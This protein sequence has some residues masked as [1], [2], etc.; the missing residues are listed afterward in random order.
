MKILHTADWHLGTFR[1]PVKDGVNLRSEDTKRCLDELVKMAGEAH[2]DFVLISGDVFDVGRLVS[3]RCCDEIITATQY[4]RELS[5][6][7]DQVV[8]MRGTPNHDG[9]GQFQV[10]NEIFYNCSNVHVVTTPQVLSFDK[11]DIAVLPGFG[12]GVYR[13]KHPGLSKEEENAALSQEIGNIVTG[14]KAQ[15]S[16]GKPSILM[17]HYSVPGCNTES[18]QIMMPAQFEPV[19]L[20]DSLLAADYDLVALGHIHRPQQI[21]S[22]NWFY[23]GAINTMNFNDEGQE[24]GFWMHYFKPDY[25]RNAFEYNTSVFY[26]TPV[27]DFK[28]IFL[29]NDD[30]SQFNAGEVDMVA[31]Y[32]WR[33]EIEDKIVRIHYRC[34][35]ENARALNTAVLEKE[36]LDDGAFM[37]WEIL[38]EKIEDP[39]NKTELSGTTD[40]EENL[41]QYLEEKQFP[42]DR[43][44]DLVMKAKPVISD[45]AAKMPTAANT[46]IF[47]PVEISVENYRNYE[48]ETFNFGDITFCTING[49]NGAG[50][51]SL[52]MDAIIDCLY[53]KRFDRYAVY[54]NDSCY[55]CHC[56]FLLSICW[57][58]SIFIDR[59]GPDGI[60]VRRQHRFCRVWYKEWRRSGNAADGFQRSRRG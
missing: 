60:Y 36:L 56:I 10:L 45:A 16:L 25:V 29:D 7:A 39:V 49:Q 44:Q 54:V 8:V 21:L 32:K 52:F 11:A 3:D 26:N 19:I 50:K 30:I 41:I 18:G 35:E 9:L 34:S 31:T 1:S 20:P 38:P 51:S 40:P 22:N 53:F 23:S 15:C 43:V 17:A 12:S 14:L 59:C 27:R 57:N 4:I 58:Q 42:P 37:V 24:R 48:K 47:E 5:A 28:T 6:V 55:G 46:G 33:G 2:P 13:T